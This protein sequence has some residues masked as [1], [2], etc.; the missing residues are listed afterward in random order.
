KKIAK[1]YPQLKRPYT[2]LLDKL[3]QD[4]FDPSLHIHPLTGNLKGKYACSLTYD[5][6]VLFKVS[7]DTIHLLDIGSHDE[8]INHYYFCN[9]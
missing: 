1:K 6:R 3:V 9:F 4:P 2:E 7:D 5:L 8:V